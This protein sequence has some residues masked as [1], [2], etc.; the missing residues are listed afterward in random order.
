MARVQPPMNQVIDGVFRAILSDGD[1][2]GYQKSQTERTQKKAELTDRLR[3]ECLTAIERLASASV[4]PSV[5]EAEL[6]EAAQ[7][8]AEAQ[9]LARQL[10]A[11]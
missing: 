8:V 3:V 5:A 2:K 9:E 6:I 1:F 4:C 11:L 7:H 10:E